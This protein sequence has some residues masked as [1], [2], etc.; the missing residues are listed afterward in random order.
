[1]REALC[2]ASYMLR[3]DPVSA[4][5]RAD[6]S[7]GWLDARLQKVGIEAPSFVLLSSDKGPFAVTVTNDLDQPVRVR[8]KA[9]TRDDL[10]IQAPEQIDLEA[11]TRQTVDLTAEAGLDR[12]PPGPAG[13]SPTRTASPPARST[14]STSAPTPSAT[15]SG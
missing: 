12:R 5:V 15:S 1:M 6:A 4:Q 7:T 10:V 8:I 2:T 3:D 13:G 11:E 14:R 9:Q